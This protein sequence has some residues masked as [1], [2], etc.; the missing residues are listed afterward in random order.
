[1]SRTLTATDLEDIVNGACLFGAG[2]GGPITLGKTL[3]TQI[4]DRGT[5]VVLAEPPEMS[6]ADSCCVSAG[7]G[8]PTAAAGGFPFDAATHAF[9]ALGQVRGRA[10]THVMP[11]EI[12]AAN[13]ILPMTV[14]ASK[15]IPILDAAG[16]YRAVPQIMQS[17]FATR[18]A[19]IG[20]VVLANAEQ[21]LYFDG[22][23]PPATDATMRAIIS[24]GTF[25]QDAGVALWAMDGPTAQRVSLPGTTERARSLGAALRA[26]ADPVDAVCAFLGGTVL[27]RGKIV[28]DPEQTAGGFDVGVVE[29]SDGSDTVRVINQNE[30]LVAWTSAETHPV[31]LAPDLIV[32]MT[33]D[34]QPFSNADLEL[35]TGKEVVVITAPADPS[36][37]DPKMIEAFL[38][39]LRSSGYGGPWAPVS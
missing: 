39:V 9:D 27:I 25:K 4:S 21:Q 35:A 38:P 36:M 10:F 12:G 33:S 5:P 2:G 20:T 14:A 22:Q 16:S 11:A 8:S 34:G 30:N 26:A 7:V 3:V 17:T 6:A 32:F 23:D 13:S 37:R 24:G 18:G 29:I 19:P 28:A 31:A 15:S 1:M